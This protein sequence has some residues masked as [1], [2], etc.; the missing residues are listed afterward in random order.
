MLINVNGLEV[1]VNVDRHLVDDI[2]LPC[3]ADV[4][5]HGRDGRRRFVFLAAPPG[6]GKSTLAAVVQQRAIALDLDLDTIGIDGFHH[7]NSYL[8][9]HTAPGDRAAATLSSIKGAPE[10]FDVAKLEKQLI[11]SSTRGLSWPTYDR[12]LHD[13]VPASQA[14]RADLVLVE[15]N[16]LLLD[17]PG[18]REL[19]RHSIFNI[20]IEAEPELLRERLIER[21]MRGGMDQAAATRF[22]ES[23]DRPN[24]ERV[25]HHTD[26]RK[27]DL[28][29][30]MN[31][32]GTINQGGS[33]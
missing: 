22:Y 21:K 13:V 16:W 12:T 11:A 24:I 23:S 19:S 18:W 4:A 33:Q 17:E 31:A 1:A 6:V 8:A 32:D 14:I 2:L 7:P 28:T 5:G 26:R 10:T 20:F 27:V 3:L 15:G 29:L 9:T 30:R 25:L